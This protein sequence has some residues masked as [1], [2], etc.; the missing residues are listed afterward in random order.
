M[1]VLFID[2]GN[3]T[4]DFRTYNNEI[5]KKLIRPLTNDEYYKN[6]HNLDEYFIKESVDFNKIIFSSVVPEWTG[7]I[8]DLCK[9][10]NIDYIDI[11]YSAPHNYK[12]FKVDKFE[13]L[14]SDFIANYYATTKKYNFQDCIVIS[15]GT[16]T[17]ISL[18]Q[19]N[20]FLGTVIAPGLKT[21]LDGLISKAALLKN[22]EYEKSNLLIGTNTIDAISIGVYNMHYIMIKN[23]IKTLMKNYDINNVIITGGYS[24]NFEK[25][26]VEDNFIYDEELIFKGLLNF[27]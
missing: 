7:I 20:I 17:T 4:V 13:V 5:F 3:T 24:Q 12:N 15:M 18:I 11:K 25:D 19:N 21:S 23:Y 6:L 22:F 9:L 2:V 8:I 14:G 27:I 16:A 10:R 26:I 1:K